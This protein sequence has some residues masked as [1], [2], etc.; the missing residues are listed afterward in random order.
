MFES[1]RWSVN[2]ELG[3]GRKKGPTKKERGRESR[4]E[5]GKRREI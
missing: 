1:E 4:G 3:E 2:R 5:I